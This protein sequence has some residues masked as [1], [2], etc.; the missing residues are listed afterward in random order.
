MCCRLVSI[1]YFVISPFSFISIARLD[2]SS[3]D[4]VWKTIS[5]IKKD[6]TIV[7][8]S[9][10]GYEILNADNV[11]VVSKGLLT[12]TGNPKELLKN[13]DSYLR[14]VQNRIKNSDA[15]KLTAMELLKQ[16]SSLSISVGNSIEIKT[17][18]TI[19]KVPDN[20]FISLKNNQ[21]TN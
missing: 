7:I 3:R 12:E 16:M 17:D 20:F 19:E 14:S 11:A 15:D 21:K 10:D 2:S 13:K 1:L 6:K 4:A 9:H 5:E 8:V 18:K